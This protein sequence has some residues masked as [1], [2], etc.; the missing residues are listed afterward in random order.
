MPVLSLDEIKRQ[1]RLDGDDEDRHL[2]LLGAAAEEY[3]A[4]YLD[5]PIPWLDSEQQPVAV[6]SAV[7]M[8]LLLVIGDLYENREGQFVGTISSDNPA[9][10]SLLTPYRVGMGI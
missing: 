9:V 6:P 2:E 8:A 4:N 3:A 7:K 10:K 5:R 1:L